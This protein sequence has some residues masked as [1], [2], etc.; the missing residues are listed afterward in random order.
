VSG[1]QQGDWLAIQQQTAARL[2]Q[3]VGEALAEVA[4]ERWGPAR[5]RVWEI[6]PN[7]DEATWRLYH[8]TARAADHRYRFQQLGVRATI[9]PGGELVAFQVDNG[10][11]FLALAE[12]SGTS[13]RRGLRH[14]IAKGL[15]ELESAEPPFLVAGTGLLDRFKRSIRRGG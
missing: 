9:A 10:D 5:G 4:R 13:L 15:P 12:T 11:E 2:D 7:L 8:P 14:L 1:S 3:L 6:V